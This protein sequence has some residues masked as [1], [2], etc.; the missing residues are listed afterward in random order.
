MSRLYSGR[1]AYKLI[2]E[3]DDTSAASERFSSQ[4]LIS[5][6]YTELNP[7]HPL[8]GPDGKKD[9]V[10]Q[11]DGK[12][13]IMACYFP[14]G[15]KS[16]KETLDKYKNDYLGVK[17]NQVN[18]IAF[19]TNQELSLGE[20][21]ELETIALN[22]NKLADI[23]HLERIST[24]VNIPSN[25]GIRLEFLRI[26]MTAEEQLSALAQKDAKIHELMNYIMQIKTKDEGQTN[27]AHTGT[28]MLSETLRYIDNYS[29]YRNGASA[30]PIHKCSY[31]KYGVKIASRIHSPFAGYVSIGI[32]DMY[33]SALYGQTKSIEVI[34]CPKCGN[35]DKL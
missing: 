33:L 4:I 32:N 2:R 27:H 20:R 18:G 17:N 12:K 6:G 1:D 26:E 8:G 24:I 19:I 7:S 16:F 14:N 35:V 34:T 5:E 22:D 13:F 15:Q 31:C 29:V 3:W 25:Y 23:Y 10:C 28:L 30:E 21:Q 11:K 9:A